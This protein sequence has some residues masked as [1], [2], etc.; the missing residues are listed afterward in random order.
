M[1][2][3][4]LY[5]ST[6]HRSV[7]IWTIWS[8]VSTIFIETRQSESASPVLFKE[9]VPGGLASRTLEQ[10]IESR[11]NSR[12]RLKLD[13]GYTY[14]LAE[15]RTGVMKNQMN[16]AMPMLAERFSNIKSWKIE[17][18]MVQP[19]LDGH[20][21]LI[22]RI[23]NEYIAYSRRGKPITTIGHI[24]KDL[25]FPDGYILDGE[26]YCHGVALQ[27][28]ASWAKRIQTNTTKLSFWCY[29]VIT[30]YEDI[31]EDR[32]KFLNDQ[33]NFGGM[34]NLLGTI[35]GGNLIDDF[36]MGTHLQN[37]INDGYEGVIL[38]PKTGVYHIGRRHK[39]LIKVK[40]WFDD[41]FKVIEVTKSKSGLAVLHM[42]AENGESFKA[43][44]PGN[45]TQKDDVL[46]RSEYYIGN[47]VT[48]E[49]PNKT[50]KGIPF[51]PIA[52]RWVTDI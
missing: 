12:V 42:K 16:L 10:Q 26:L 41:N 27:T 49:Y 33:V 4:I 34:S 24:L 47:S 18:M 5:R 21:C 6:K 40:Q 11:I 31:Y 2:K 9:D 32:L 44:A 36:S 28:I 52:V 37:T 43:T 15:A 17:D 22:A 30:P 8:E 3:T 19:K 39:D 1:N 48:I 50:L 25:D 38:R 35:D 45:R 14:S 46:K 51:Q 23:G 13:H 20:R 29:D 7:S